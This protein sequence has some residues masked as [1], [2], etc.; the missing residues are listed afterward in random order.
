MMKST[1]LATLIA[2]A[3][4]FAP[5]AKQQTSTSLKAFENELG[6]QPPVSVV[7]WMSWLLLSERPQQISAAFTDPFLDCPVFFFILLL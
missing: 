5:A 1:I 6:A 4:A 3:A 7:G 2:S